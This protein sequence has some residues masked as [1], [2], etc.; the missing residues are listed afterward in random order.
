MDA[1]DR[2]DEHVDRWRPLLPG[3]DPDTEGAVTRVHFLS[4]HLKQDRERYLADAG[5]HLH[6]FETLHALVAR[7]GRAAPSALAADLGRPANS[8][9]G[10]L[11]GLERRGLV[12]RTPSPTDRRR[13]DV[14]L[15][16]DGRDAWQ[17]AM[18]ALGAE[19]DRLFAALT[20]DERR[21]LSDLL[22]RIML[23]AEDRD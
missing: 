12:E 22:R 14:A 15:T 1:R 6:E 17:A 19:E 13:V 3:L 23:R 4:R 20:P 8:V 2:T 5:L 7:G 16:A 21:Q 10:R 11:D 9:T 18:D